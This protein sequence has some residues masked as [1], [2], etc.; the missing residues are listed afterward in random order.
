M[1]AKLAL[2]LLPEV[3]KSK[4][5]FVNVWES[6]K[7]T[8]VASETAVF[9][10]AKVVVNVLLAKL[11]DLFVSVSVVSFNTIVPVASGIVTVLSAVGSVTVNTVSKSS[12]VVPSNV[13]ELV[14]S[15]VFESTTVCVPNTLKFPVTVKLPGTVIAL[16]KLNVNV[17]PA[18]AVVIWFAVP[19]TV[20]VSP[21]STALLPESPARVIVEF[22]N[23][24]FAI[25]VS[26][27]SGPLIV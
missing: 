6:S 21:K 24:V 9:N 22:D 15:I 1:F 5:L 27:L 13:N 26:V 11:I 14:T 12:E 23:E 20:N 25:F 8:S 18:W 16:G 19:L 17:S 7:S 2:T 10:N 3:V 4:V